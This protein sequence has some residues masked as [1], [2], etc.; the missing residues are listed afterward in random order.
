MILEAA[1]LY[2]REGEK[3]NFEKDFV[4]AGQ[5]ISSIEG[6][7]KHSLQRCLEVDHKYLLLV[8]WESIENQTCIITGKNYYI[9]IMNHF[10]L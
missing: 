5:Y 3:D 10:P 9:I 1:Y 4:F 7:I 2:I 6:Y 8:E